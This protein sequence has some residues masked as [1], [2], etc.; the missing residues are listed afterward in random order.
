M[1]TTI[2]DL[3][4]V[5]IFTDLNVEEYKEEIIDT[6]TK[7]HNNFDTHA[8]SEHTLYLQGQKIMLNEI[9]KFIKKS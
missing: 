6:L 4:K 1:K 5:R 9:I 7:I 8:M 3:Q 2:K